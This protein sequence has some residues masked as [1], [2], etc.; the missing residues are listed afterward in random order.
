[1]II[2]GFILSYIL[3]FAAF[4]DPEL[5]GIDFP[6]YYYDYLR[7][8]I[9]LFAIIYAVKFSYNSDSTHSL[10]YVIIAILFNPIEPFY[11]NSYL[12]SVF[13]LMAAGLFAFLNP[14]MDSKKIKEI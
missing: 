7:I 12:W 2:V 14:W 4:S 11:F 8:I 9:T 1:M 5:M 13:D 6:Y 3:F 10:L